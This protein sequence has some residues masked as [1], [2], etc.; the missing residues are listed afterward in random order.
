MSRLDS[1]I[2]RLTAQRACL[3]RAFELIGDIDGPVVELGLGNGRTFDHLRCHLAEREIFVFERSPQAHSDS[4]PDSKHLIIGNLAQT[5]PDALAIM[6]EPAA[7][8]HSDIGCGDPEIDRETARLIAFH[9]P[10][11]VKRGGIVLSDQVIDCKGFHSLPLPGGVSEGR[12]TFLHHCAEGALK[13]DNN[14]SLIY[15]S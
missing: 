9:L 4:T 14:N 11:L 5:L 6:G 8:L 2:R 7:M 13:T 10:R 12:Y 3:N 15:Q 1:F